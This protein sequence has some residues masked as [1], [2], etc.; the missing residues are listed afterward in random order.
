MKKLN[1]FL[2]GVFL[3]FG[4]IGC[5]VIQPGQQAMRWNPY[6]KGLVTE[7]VYKD[8]IVWTWPWNGVVT[9][10][11]KWQTYSENVDILTKDELH[12]RLTVSVTMRPIEPE[13]PKLEL[14]VGQNYYNE[15]VRP[16]FISIT[17]NVFSN[18]DYTLVSPKSPEIEMAIFNELIVKTK[19]KHLEFDNITVDHIDYPQVVTAAV[20]R[21]LAVQQNIEQK[22]YEIEIAERDAEIQRIRAKGQQDSQKIIDSGLSRTYLQ[23]KALEVQ[24]KLS[25]S[26]N[27]KFYFVPLGKDGLPIIVDSK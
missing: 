19:G 1:Y 5:S 26:N 3:S 6:G 12:I 21:K 16:E 25:T 22:D 10:N 18:Y 20:N 11:T 4:I 7:K 8:G 2:F 9:Y 13:L 23:Y 27:A 14:E 17:R 24:E 15:V